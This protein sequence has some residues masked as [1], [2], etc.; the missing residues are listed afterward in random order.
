M[1]SL[2]P[3]PD[4]APTP[5]PRMPPPS[6]TKILLAVSAVITIAAGTGVALW[7]WAGTA[8]L[9]GATLVTARFTALSTALS[10]A[11]GGGGIL[12]LYIAWRRQRSTEIALEHTATAL[13]QK[14]RD[15]A[16]IARAYDL[17]RE[18]FETNRLHQE[19]VAAATERA[20]EAR[21]ITDLYSKSVEQL[22][23]DK[24]PVRLGGLYALKR[25]A[26]DHP[27]QR[28]TIVDV[29]CAYLRMPYI[30]PGDLPEDDT[31]TA[32]GDVYR[33]RAQELEVRLTAQ[34]ILTHH[35]NPGGNPDKSVTTFWS[36]ITLDLTG[37]TLINL[38][39]D[40]I[41]IHAATF[42]RA[43]FSGDTQ[44][45]RA[46]FTG[47][48]LFDRA[49]FS[50]G[51]SF[52]GAQ[53]GG[54]A[55]FEGAQIGGRALFSWA[56]FNDAMFGNAEFRGDVRFNKAEFNRDARFIEVTFSSDA[57][58]YEAEFNAGAWFD[59]AQFSADAMFTKARF[60]IDTPFGDGDALFRE[61][62]FSSDAQ[63]DRAQF[64]AGAQF[65]RA[66]FGGD[67]LF[68]GAKFSRNIRFDEAEFS[69]SVSDEI[70]PY[71]P[72]GRDV[73]PPEGLPS[74]PDSAT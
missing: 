64:N 60:S 65:D 67:A 20:D 68:D 32:I 62:K 1:T 10:I 61:V 31:N 37:A 52:E 14:E 35:L 19:R 7:W 58:F 48:A 44:F 73:A 11:V 25:L 69:G 9:N 24:A 66:Q 57:Q 15:Q 12:A 42:T 26:Q 56:K 27:E 29:L 22:G 18:T 53:F 40:D 17:Q 49:K 3:Q 38:E 47:D 39:L 41:A 70:G 28:Q 59:R 16:D 71:R 5:A 4:P 36:D 72:P 74:N 2:I 50:G 45:D 63:F 8:G 13:A 55:L 54:R 6:R 43:R 33:E 51:A 30:L 46:K 34:R 21:R 23:S